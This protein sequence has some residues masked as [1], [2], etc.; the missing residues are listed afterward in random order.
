MLSNFDGD[1]MR[2]L[3]LARTS[4]AV[5]LTW[6]CGAKSTDD[7]AA[8]TASCD[9]YVTEPMPSLTPDEF[10]EGLAEGLDALR[11]LEG[12][13]RGSHC[14]DAYSTREIDMKITAMPVIPDEISVV[15]KAPDE[16]VGC[17]CAAD[18]MFAADNALDVVALVPPFTLFFD[19]DELAPVDPAVDQQ[20]FL[21]GGA[22]YAGQQG[23]FFRACE[24]TT[25]EPYLNSAYDSVAVNVRIQTKSETT[26]LSHL[27]AVTLGVSLIKQ[28]QG[29]APVA[30]DVIDFEKVQP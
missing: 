17:G 5:A 25:I 24:N 23:L 16:S 30:C 11:N 7:S 2:P 27:G 20:E 1:P 22:L 4:L 9:D 29:V 19:P 18:P 12:L 26:P 13:W 28:E 14:L 15:R 3:T 8:P 21:V 10:P 6:G